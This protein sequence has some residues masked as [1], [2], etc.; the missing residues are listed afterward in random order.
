MERFY[1]APYSALERYS[2]VGTPAQI[3]DWLRPYV[4]AGAVDFNIAPIAA[5]DAERVAG[6][7]EI[8]RLITA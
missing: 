1:G 2:P 6:A 4:D 8:R 5:T 7:A 3:A